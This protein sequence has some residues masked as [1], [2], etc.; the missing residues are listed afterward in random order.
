[1]EAA[2]VPLGNDKSFLIAHPHKLGESVRVSIGR[3]LGEGAL[4]IVR[5]LNIEGDRP[6]FP[7]KSHFVI[8]STT[9]AP[10]PHL[11]VREMLVHLEVSNMVQTDEC[12]PLILCFRG[13][14]VPRFSPGTTTPSEA[15]TSILTPL[16]K[17]VPRSV[18]FETLFVT[19]A[20]IGPH[21][22]MIYERVLGPTLHTLLYP[23]ADK[24]ARPANFRQLGLSLLHA[25]KVLHDKNIV[26]RDI[27]PENIMVEGDG[28]KLIDLGLACFLREG[29]KNIECRVPEGTF[30]FIGPEAFEGTPRYVGNEAPIPD[31][32][33]NLKQLDLF[34]VGATL[35]ELLVQRSIHGPSV[36]MSNIMAWLSPGEGGPREL[37]LAWPDDETTPFQYLVTRMVLYDSERRPSL[38]EVIAEWT[39]KMEPPA[40]A[41]PA[42]VEALGPVH[43]VAVAKGAVVANAANEAAAPVVQGGLRRKGKRTTKKARTKKQRSKR[44]RRGTRN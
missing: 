35:Y 9:K 37:E 44:M 20:D 4:G 8:K 17:V 6:L 33:A 7:G 24:T 16:S 31:R 13:I 5:E 15:L 1:M 23:E 42:N 28:V 38:E 41:P 34:A 27:K 2:S 22:H 21:P 32:I 12:N 36:T 29:K 11:L 43:V 3:K 25:V 19:D 18:L 14:L 39:A 30:Q 26:H 40:N 10:K